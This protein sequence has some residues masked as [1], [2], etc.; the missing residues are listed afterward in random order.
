MSAPLAKSNF[1]RLPKDLIKVID[2]YVHH[3]RGLWQAMAMWNYNL[4]RSPF[5]CPGDEYYIMNDA[6]FEDID[7][8]NSEDGVLRWRLDKHWK[9]LTCIT[10]R[11]VAMLQAQLCTMSKRSLQQRCRVRGLI[12][13]VCA[14][15]RELHNVWRHWTDPTILR[16][17][18]RAS[19]VHNSLKRFRD[20]EAELELQADRQAEFVTDLDW[21]SEPTDDDS[22][23]YALVPY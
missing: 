21:G 20:L 5:H 17:R 18:T 15:Y 13:D 11:F 22:A 10:K 7:D 19:L 14:R 8:A 9:P 6:I 12:A 2:S 3:D 16:D 4:D 1:G 23:Q